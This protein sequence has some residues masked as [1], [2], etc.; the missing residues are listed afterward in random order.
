MNAL[1]LLDSECL[2]EHL[3]SLRYLLSTGGMPIS[4]GGGK[5]RANPHPVLLS[6]KLRLWVIPGGHT[7]GAC[8]LIQGLPMAAFSIWY[9]ARHLCCW[10]KA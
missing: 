4:G 8:E 9:G 7:Q 6:G 10:P 2:E 1:C 3:A 5:E